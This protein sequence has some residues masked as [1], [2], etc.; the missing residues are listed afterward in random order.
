MVIRQASKDDITQIL[1]LT[2]SV[3]DKH[4]KNRPDILVEHPYHITREK[5]ER[6]IQSDDHYVIV[7]ADDTVNKIAGVILCSI[8]SY[9]DDLKYQDA[10]IISIEDTCVDSAFRGNHVGS[11]LLDYIKKLAR[12]IGCSRL[13]S[14]VWAFNNESRSFFQANGFAIQRMIME[15]AI[16]G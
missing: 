14:N 9:A 12:T 3:A 6:N 10:K 11:M 1:M 13:E 16:N 4:G 5:L 15:C 8:R 7:A 2:N